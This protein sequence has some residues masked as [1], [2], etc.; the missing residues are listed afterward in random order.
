MPR[1]PAA[2]TIYIQHQ[3]GTGQALELLH[4]LTKTNVTGKSSPHSANPF[5]ATLGLRVE[6][7]PI[8]SGVG[9]QLDVGVRLVPLYIYRTVEAF[10]ERMGEYVREALQEGLCGWRVT[11]CAVTISDCGYRAP[12]TTAADFRKLTPLVLVQA[13]EQAR[14]VVCEPILRVRL[15]LPPETIGAVLAVLARLGAV[16]QTPSLHGDLAT[17]ETVLPAA[18]VR[19]LQRHL[20]GLTA[21]EGV[22]DSDFGGYRP[23]SGTQPT[24]RRTT[25]N[26]LNREEYLTQLAHGTTRTAGPPRPASG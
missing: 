24:R 4:A 25:A 9:V 21:G 10:I 19:E 14:T 2:A 6:P 11:D 13:L 17:I 8:G 12:G 18:R 20:P 3:I 15:E 7:A 22:L 23:V 26:P 1:F 5:P 16:A